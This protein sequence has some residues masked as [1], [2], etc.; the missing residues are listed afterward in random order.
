M[1]K[2]AFTGRWVPPVRLPSRTKGGSKLGVE[3]TFRSVSSGERAKGVWCGSVCRRQVV[4]VSSSVSVQSALS[5]DRAPYVWQCKAV[6]ECRTEVGLLVQCRVCE[7]FCTAAATSASF[8]TVRSLLAP[9]WVP[10]RRHRSMPI[11][12][13]HCYHLS[14]L[15]VK[16]SLF[17]HPVV[18]RP[19]GATKR[20][21]HHL[22]WPLWRCCCTA[23]YQQ[24]PSALFL[25][26][27][28][29]SLY[30]RSSHPSWCVLLV[31]S[32]HS[33]I[34][35]RIALYRAVISYHAR[36]CR[37]GRVDYHITCAAGLTPDHRSA[38]AFIIAPDRRILRCF[39]VQIQWIS[40]ILCIL[41]PVL[42]L[43]SLTLFSLCYIQLSLT[44]F[45]SKSKYT[46]SCCTYI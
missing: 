21:R 15:Q 32:L 39:P 41:L 25:A 43:C 18:L 45:V 46:R 28:Q 19:S 11:I 8:C 35:S 2:T 4:R 13:D 3:R 12:T 42:S 24:P 30:Y 6:C 5:V 44:I 22:F 38:R 10:C 29:R 1:N 17:W 37:V 34:C 31:I 27:H 20:L 23:C 36:V 16:E 7:R 33:C 9:W 40:L 14:W 26:S